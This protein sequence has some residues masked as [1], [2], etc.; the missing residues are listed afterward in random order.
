MQ[1]RRPHHKDER[2]GFTLIEL[3]IAITIFLL[4]SAVTIAAVQ[5]FR[6]SGQ[7]VDG[8][9]RQVQSY[10]SGA[11]DRAV[12]STKSANGARNRGVRFLPDTN[13]VAV[14][15]GGNNTL[16]ACR[17]M[18][19]V[20]SAGTYPPNA[21][22][23]SSF[24]PRL[25][26]LFLAGD[27]PNTDPV[28]RLELLPPA[29]VNVGG[30]QVA[31]PWGDHPAGPAP[32][33]SHTVEAG[34]RPGAG[35]NNALSAGLTDAWTTT[36]LNRVFKAGLLGERIGTTNRF[37]TRVRVPADGPWVTAA[38]LAAGNDPLEQ[39]LR[40]A[41][42][43]RVFLL[44]DGGSVT[45]AEYNAAEPVPGNPSDIE[46]QSAQRGY[47]FELRVVPMAGEAVRPLPAGTA[48][49][50][51]A[52][53]RFGAIPSAWRAA[54]TGGGGAMD[55]MFDPSG[56][57]AGDLAAGG[58]VHLPIVSDEDLDVNGNAGPFPARS[59]LP[60]GY[61]GTNPDAAP[62]FDA[63]AG[64]YGGRGKL[65]EELIVSVNTQTGTINV[66]SVDTVDE[67]GNGLADDPF[68]FAETGLEA[69]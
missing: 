60:L 8:A 3:L 12:L 15:G 36:G 31:F 33:R 34:E 63:G 52:A 59:F 39:D 20:E 47:A 21:Q 58:V 1:A 50:L 53:A 11:R 54:L 66:S 57:V 16:F 44:T 25:E 23:R 64:V 10:L 9:A 51:H 37:L 38:I 30:V 17:A 19:Y 41:G 26:M 22:R 28:E 69:N 42:I 32:A 45:P 61:V 56:Q 2:R 6:T 62:A 27:D 4:V 68:R 49:D 24:S 40:L 14:D 43:G 5:G 46:Y 35:V 7:T 13:L 55:L 48:I 29:F 65:G 18:Q 67:D